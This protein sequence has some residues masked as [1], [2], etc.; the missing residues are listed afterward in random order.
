MIEVITKK[1]FIDCLSALVY[2]HSKRMLHRDIKPANILI[3]KNGNAKFSDFGLSKSI[4]QTYA[5]T[6]VGTYDYMAPE[7]CRDDKSMRYGTKTDVWSI[8]ATF[9]NIITKRVP[10]V[11]DH[12]SAKELISRR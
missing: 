8:C 4:K 9:Y 1:L 3:D 6:F 11:E 12:H 2:M 7:I 5:K 10:H